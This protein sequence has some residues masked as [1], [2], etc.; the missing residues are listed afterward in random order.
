MGIFF[1]LTIKAKVMEGSYLVH[2]WD[3]D[4]E[5]RDATQK[6]VVHVGVAFLVLL[7]LIK[8]KCLHIHNEKNSFLMRVV[9]PL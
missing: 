9:I 7:Y 2:V 3:E 8:V 6:Q 4:K 5:P 1:L